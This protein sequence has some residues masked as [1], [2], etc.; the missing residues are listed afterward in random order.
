[1]SGINASIIDR[2]QGKASPGIGLRDVAKYGIYI[3]FCGLFIFLS[4]SSPTFLTTENILNILRQSSL[5]GIIAVGMTFVII[6]GGI[7]LSVGSIVALSAVVATS[8][9]HPDTYPVAVPIALGLGVGAAVG[10]LNGV[11]IAKG[12]IA[13]FVVTLGMM[14]MARGVGLVFS[15]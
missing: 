6:T 10:L 15:S 4:I 9:A 2:A 5:N 12:A 3:A 7:D 14:T 13:P 8:F 11:V 1:M